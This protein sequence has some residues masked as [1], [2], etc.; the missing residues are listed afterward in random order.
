MGLRSGKM[1]NRGT[2]RG[3]IGDG[4]YC[5]NGGFGGWGSSLVLRCEMEDSVPGF[6]CGPAG[7]FLKNFFEKFL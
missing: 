4:V 7:K 6:A 3:R 1:G 5:E 2:H